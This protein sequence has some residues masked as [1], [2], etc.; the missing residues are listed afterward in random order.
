[1]PRITFAEHVAAGQGLF[2]IIAGRQQR[3]ANEDYRNRALALE[4][5][6]SQRAGLHADRAGLISGVQTLGDLAR[7]GLPEPLQQY[8]ISKLGQQLGLPSDMTKA[9]LKTGQEDREGLADLLQSSLADNP[10]LSASALRPLLRSDPLKAMQTMGELYKQQRELV[11]SRAL[12]QI[13]EQPGPSPDAPNPTPGM[14]TTFQAPAAVVPRRGIGRL[15]P[16]QQEIIREAAVRNIPAAVALA[17]VQQESGFDPNA[18]GKSGEIGLFQI[19]PSTGADLGYTPEQLRNPRT[20]VRAGLDYLAQHIKSRG[21]IIP[22]LTRYNGGGDPNYAAN[23]LRHVPQYSHLLTEEAVGT[24]PAVDTTQLQIRIDQIDARAQ[25]ITRSQ[26][27]DQGSP[28]VER[29]LTR[30]D[31]ERQNLVQ[32]RDRQTTLRTS[33]TQEQSAL[34]QQQ[35][36]Q[37]DIEKEQ[38]AVSGQLAPQENLKF[39]LDIQNNI[40]AEQTIKLFNEARPGYQ[41]MQEAERESSGLGDLAL[42]KAFER[43]INP[44]NAVLQSE[45]TTVQD[46]QGYLQRFFQL[47]VQFFTGQRLKPEFR[48]AILKIG[49]A[50][51]TRLA[52]NADTQI[53]TIY[54]PIAAQAGIPFGELYVPASR[55]LTEKPVTMRDIVE[56]APKKDRERLKSILKDVPNVP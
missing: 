12:R 19:L 23:V 34:L 38:R 48:E 2:N 10:T 35:R 20:N 6:Q 16:I 13:M 37:Q 7:S 33:R 24:S 27:L 47:P 29:I 41:L 30:L 31:R 28:E 17:Q 51:I 46:A 11:G 26:A 1:M 32:E 15:T 8:A 9:L 43:T 53:E 21:G 49:K 22:G 36:T 18:I 4:E 52:Q 44:G 50:T 5:E 14:P 40:R 56:H 54:Q 55:L 25:A 42:V 39:R 3:Q 45:A